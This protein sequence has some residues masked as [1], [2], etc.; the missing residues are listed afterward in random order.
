VVT[1]ST[2]TL[3]ANG[4]KDVADLFANR[5]GEGTCNLKTAAPHLNRRMEDSK[6][7]YE[8][9]RGDVIFHD[10]WLFHRT[11]PFDRHFL[12]ELKDDPLY[13]RYS[14]RYG[15]GTSTIPPGYGLELSVLWNPENGGKPADQ[16]CQQDGPWYP[17]TWPEVNE[18]EMEQLPSL[19]SDK[20]PVAEAARK[21][22]QKEMKPYL[23]EMRQK[24]KRNA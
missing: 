22:R 13:R 2:K 9:K 12:H 3:P 6:R 1:G 7:I 18:K 5:T 8:M 23:E 16:V 11:V 21:A 15:P 14:V 20:I 19:L 10:R 24:Q 17:Q 4:F